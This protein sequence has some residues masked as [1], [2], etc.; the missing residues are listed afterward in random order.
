MSSGIYCYRDNERDNRIVYVGKDSNISIHK[1]CREHMYPS[2]YHKQ[3]F[4]R[5]LQRNPDRYSYYVL[6]QGDFEDNWLSALEILYIRKYNPKYNYTIGGDGTTGFKHNLSTKKKMSESHI[7]EKN[8]FYGKHHTEESK[9]KMREA[10]SGEKSYW[11]NRNRTDE[12]KLNVSKSSNTTGYFRVCKIKR[13][14]CK[15][16]FLWEYKYYDENKK[17]HTLTST[18]I[19]TLKDKVLA[20]GEIWH[21]FGGD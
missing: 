20:I 18:N 19:D 7:G 8:H 14:K 15:Q 13:P 12:N 6:R 2:N 9:Q 3:P 4:N 21:E 5:I 10:V 11:Y 17:R 1:R 16:G